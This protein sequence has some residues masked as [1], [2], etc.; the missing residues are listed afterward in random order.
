MLLL[1]ACP[2]CHGDLV[3]ES[4]GQT[5]YLECV[6]CGHTLSREQEKALGIRVT[7]RGLVHTVA[8]PH[9]QNQP[10]AAANKAAGR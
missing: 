4:D 2:H 3:V 9:T 6:Q 10:L 1:H 7:R 5:G 8:R